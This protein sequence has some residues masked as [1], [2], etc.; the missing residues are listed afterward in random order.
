MGL[1]ILCAGCS[2]E[3]REQA[4]AEV[5][6]ALADRVSSGDWSVSL[7]KLA[8]R[9]SVTLDAPS[10]RLRGLSVTAPPGGLAQAIR[11]ALG[12]ASAPVAAA[13]PAR[14]PT[15]PAGTPT[16]PAAAGGRLR[17]EKC[18]A[19]FVVVYDAQPGEPMETAPVACPHCW[20]VNRVGI[21]AEAALTRDYRAEKA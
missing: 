7:V 19:G 14:Q 17:C 16:V 21:G 3:E 8:G 5:S 13:P 1:K 4:E 2:K 10:A 9:W 15:A 6:R 18:G 12:S 20:A 11:G